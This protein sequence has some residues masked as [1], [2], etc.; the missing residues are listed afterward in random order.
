MSKPFTQPWGFSKLDT[1]RK[2]EK[3]FFYQYVEKLPSPNNAAMERGGKMHENI[4]MYL[5]GWTSDLLSSVESW[6]VALDALKTKNFQAEQALG[7]SK[8]WALLPD[9]FHRDTWLR[10]KM[11]A[12]YLDGDKL[13]V[14]DFKSGKY[15][16][17]SDDQVELYAIAGSSMHPEAQTVSAEFWFLDTGEVYQREYT[18]AALLGL[19]KKYE[20][21]AAALY[22]DTVWEP[23]PSA[24]CRYCT[25][26]RT[27]GGPCKY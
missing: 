24:V 10:A 4:E 3:Q 27:K 15:R 20:Q 7:F 14:I 5:N 25:Y 22:V 8:A 9:W 6:K 11:D 19:R 21:A 16:I 12:K 17:P 26:S 23:R 2:C 13:T 18:K 1:Y